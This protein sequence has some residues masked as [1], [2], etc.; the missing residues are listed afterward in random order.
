MRRLPQDDFDDDDFDDESLVGR[1]T[2]SKG[3]RGGG[4]GGDLIN[5]AKKALSS[6][7]VIF[8]VA[9]CLL[10]YSRPWAASASASMSTSVPSS[11][12]RRATASDDDAVV[13][14]NSNAAV[15]TSGQPSEQPL[16][17]AGASS[18]MAAQASKATSAVKDD[19]VVV[20]DPTAATATS[21]KAHHDIPSVVTAKRAYASVIT[22]GDLTVSRSVVDEFGVPPPSPPPDGS[23]ARSMEDD[24]R[25]AR[26]AAE[27]E[28]RERM[29]MG[30]QLPSE[31]KMPTPRK[32]SPEA[33]AAKIRELEDAMNGRRLPPEAH[34]A[35]MLSS[36]EQMAHADG[37]DVSSI[38]GP[39]SPVT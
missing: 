31:R 33:L 2:P 25:R 39:F 16:A 28:Q 4:A 14:V 29:R 9:I 19:D 22:D 15:S 17:R 35:A 26:E 6:K 20:V 24:R 8:G 23:A 12:M 30:A 3:P 18:A 11:G 38:S 36:A 27:A 13:V 10:L 37:A 21:V 1:P 34:L 32:Q 5:S 7:T